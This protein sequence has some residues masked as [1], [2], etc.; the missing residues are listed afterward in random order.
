LFKQS[1]AGD[2]Q[3]WFWV[4]VG[5]FLKFEATSPRYRF[6]LKCRTVVS[7]FFFLKKHT[8]FIN[9]YTHWGT[10]KIGWLGLNKLAGCSDSCL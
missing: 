7:F 9:I 5:W 3:F 10:Q 2:S 6:H 1:E 4:L 8:V